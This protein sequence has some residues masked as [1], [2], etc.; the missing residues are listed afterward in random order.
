MQ[1]QWTSSHCVNLPTPK[2]FRASVDKRGSSQL[3]ELS[4]NFMGEPQGVKTGE[5]SLRFQPFSCLPR[6]IV[7]FF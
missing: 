6:G 7:I 3:S 4:I 5:F 2:H 1:S